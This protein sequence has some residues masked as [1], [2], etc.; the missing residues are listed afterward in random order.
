[1]LLERETVMAD[2]KPDNM[3][4]FRERIAL[5]LVMVALRIVAADTAISNHL[6]DISKMIKGEA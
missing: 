6:Y 4:T 3:L 2:K 1:M 5:T